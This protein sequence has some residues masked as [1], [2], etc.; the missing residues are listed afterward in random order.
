MWDNAPLLR[1]IANLLFGLSLAMVLYG[2]ARYVLHLPVFPLNA[3][4]LQEAP[5][6]VPVEMIER[7]VRE[8][9]QGNFFTVDLNK[10]THGI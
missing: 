8:Q 5:K 1:V 10:D 7:V 3:I 9:I 6:N 4:Q 2:V